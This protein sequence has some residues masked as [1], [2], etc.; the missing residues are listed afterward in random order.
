[1][2]LRAC[3]RQSFQ[4]PSVAPGKKRRRKALLASLMGKRWTGR[5]FR[6]RLGT[7]LP[8]PA[9]PA[10]AAEDEPAADEPAVSARLVA[11]DCRE[12]ERRSVGKR[13]VSRLRYRG[14]PYHSKQKT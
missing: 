7:I 1:M 11:G 5:P 14:S 3:Q 6:P 9:A 13:C 4:S 10:P 8:A 12:S 2:R